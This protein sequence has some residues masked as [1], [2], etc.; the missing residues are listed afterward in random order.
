M[1]GGAAAALPPPVSASLLPSVPLTGFLP[2]ARI[3]GGTVSSR[4][5]EGE[6]LTPSPPEGRV[7]L[8]D[9]PS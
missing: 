9:A 3:S 6:P 8:G 4:D 7:P 1:A 5:A 2:Y